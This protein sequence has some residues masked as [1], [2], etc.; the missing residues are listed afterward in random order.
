MV[1]QSPVVKTLLLSP[2]MVVDERD[3]SQIEQRVRAMTGRSE[4]EV[5]AIRR[6]VDQNGR[7][8]SF[9]VDIR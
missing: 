8:S 2:E 5:V 3:K 6:V 9:E 4:V 1:H 7:T